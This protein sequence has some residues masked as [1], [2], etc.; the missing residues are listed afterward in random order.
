[1]DI[2]EFKHMKFSYI[3]YAQAEGNTDFVTS[4]SSLCSVPPHLGERRV[5]PNSGTFSGS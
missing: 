4:R 5:G 2:R 3:R 1:M